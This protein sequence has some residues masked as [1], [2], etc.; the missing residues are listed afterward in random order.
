MRSRGVVVG[1]ALAVASCKKELPKYTPALMPP[2]A[3]PLV[4][5]SSTEADVM[6]RIAA[7]P[8]EELEIAKDLSLGGDQHVEFNDHKSLNIRHPK[9]GQAW[10]WDIGGSLKL[11]RLTLVGSEGC[12]WTLEHVATLAGA[13]NCP[14]NR[15]TGGTA[16]GGYWCAELDGHTVHIECGRTMNDYWLGN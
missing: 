15:K 3:A 1:F 4:L 7:L 6:A 9:F 10:L 2:S 8:K 14:G 13:K 12:A 5:G 16:D 11:G